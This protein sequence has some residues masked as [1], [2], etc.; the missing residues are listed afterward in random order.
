MPQ[1]QCILYGPR[2]A[3]DGLEGMASKKDIAEQDYILVG[4]RY[5][6]AAVVNSDYPMV[7]LGEVCDI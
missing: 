3:Q 4:E 1:V 6:A 5:K 2:G 7:E